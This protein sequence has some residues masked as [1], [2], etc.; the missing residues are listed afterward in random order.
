MNQGILSVD[1]APVACAA[2][3]TRACHGRTTQRAHGAR[4]ALPRFA[5]DDYERI[6]TFVLES[7]GLRK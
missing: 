5:I 6:I 4:Y 3:T 7:A 1:R 2:R